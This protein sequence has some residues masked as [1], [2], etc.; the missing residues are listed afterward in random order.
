MQATN[1]FRSGLRTRANPVPLVV[2]LVALTGGSCGVRAQDCVTSPPGAVYWLGA[3][4]NDDDLAGFH[5]ATSG[6]GVSFAPGMAGTGLHLEGSNA[7][8]VSDTTFV[9]ERRVFAAFTEEFWVRPAAPLQACGESD[10]GTCAIGQPWVIS[11]EHG[12]DNAPP[13]ALDAGIGVAV[14]TDGVCVGQHANFLASCLARVDTP[15]TNWTHVAVVVENKTPR[16]YIDGA[17][18]HTGLTS[19]RDFVFASFSVIGNIDDS[20]GTF[21]GEIDEVTVYDRALSDAE[22]A[23]IFAAGSAGQ[24]T[25]SCEVDLADDAWQGALVTATSPLHPGFSGNEMFGGTEGN[26]EP[27]STLFADGLPGGTIQSIEWT[28]AAPVTL[29]RLAIDAFHDPESPSFERAF[30]HLTIKARETGAEFTTI[31]D[32]DIPVPYGEGPDE[33]E[34]RTLNRCPNIRPI[35]AQEFRAEFTQDD[36]GPLSGSRVVELDALIHEPIFDD[37]FDPPTYP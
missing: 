29:D 36:E 26:P 11:P 16:I 21:S 3:E 30:R 9:E 1:A 19:S 4:R 24:C 23:S 8:V 10:S 37:G 7:K 15:L 2:G 28:T 5:N 6:S 31:Y 18:V 12:D 35:H 22:I 17:L 32:S 20:F 14:G 34:Q 27:T 33:I 13:G 25:P